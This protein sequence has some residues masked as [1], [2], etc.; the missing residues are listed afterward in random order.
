MKVNQVINIDKTKEK[1]YNKIDLINE[2]TFTYYDYLKYKLFEKMQKAKNTTLHE[3]KEKYKRLEQQENRV[4]NEHDKVFRKI[5]SDKIEVTKFLNEQ[6]KINLKP[7]DIEQYNTSYIN[8]L[9]QNEEADVV[10]KLREKNEFFLIEHQSKVDYRM[11]FRIL[12][13]EMAIIESAIDEKEYGKKSYLHPRVNAIVLYTG[14][15]KWNVAQTFN[16]TQVTSILEKSIEFA[17]YILVD[18]NNYTEEKLLETPSFMTKALLIEK[19][20]DNEQIANYIEKIVEIINKDKEN[21]SNN[22]KEIFKIML[23]QIIKNKIGKEKT[24]EF[25]KKLN[26]GGDKDMMAVFETIQ[27]DNKR[28]YRRGKKDGIVE[29]IKKGISQGISQ[30]I[31]ENSIAIAKKLLSR[32]NSKEEV[33]EITGLKIE[34]IEKLQ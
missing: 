8:N 33:A 24:D 3:Q 2:A 11:P 17:K 31:M 5:L 27:Q 9:M 34:E 15:Q 29:G 20:K 19:A 13:Y 25:L 23:T 28:I 10:Y 7:E 16:E 18:I 14:K 12:K 21:Y 26:I 6:L 30:G 1:D 22:I 4:N 32:N